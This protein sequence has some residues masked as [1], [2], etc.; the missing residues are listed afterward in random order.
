M[1]YTVLI[2]SIILL[3]SVLLLGLR[4]FFVK[5][6]RFPNI[7][8]GGIKALRDKGINCATTQDRE[9]QQ[10]KGIKMSDLVKDITD[11]Y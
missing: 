8:I 5:G 7:H 2:S 1:L 3:I 6:G 11:N 4:V 10:S 9:A